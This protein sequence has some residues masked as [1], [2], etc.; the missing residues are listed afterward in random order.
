MQF[1]L[2]MATLSIQ[3]YRFPLFYIFSRNFRPAYFPCKKNNMNL[4]IA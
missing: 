1:S 4:Y 2:A 3:I